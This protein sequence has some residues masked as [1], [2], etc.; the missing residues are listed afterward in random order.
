[1]LKGNYLITGASGSMG[2]TAL[3]RL[4]DV[5]GINVRAADLKEPRVSGDNISF[6][7]ADLK[8]LETC[9]EIVK[10]IDY[11]L[12]FAA[13]LSTAPVMAKNPV[14]HVTSNMIINSQM[15]E[16]AYFAGVKKFLWLSS[17]T[18][19]PQK[20]EPLKEEDMFKGDPP[21]NY[22]SV[23]WMSRY[24]ET[25]C[26]MYAAKLKNPMTTIIL[27]PTNI[28]SEYESFNLEDSHVLPALIRKAVERQDPIEVWGTGEQKK[29][30]VYADDVFDACLLALEKIDSFDTFNIGYG[31]EYSIKE[32]LKTILE[33]DNYNDAKI[34]HNT[35]KPST[36]SKRL[37]DTTKIKKVLGFKPKTTVKEGIAKMIKWY[38]DNQ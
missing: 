28:Y 16:V 24:T 29:D 5:P 9:K 34:I 2:T 1:M 18:G 15:L 10:N 4:K 33:I 8:N 6:V 31:K 22:F 21:D 30:L 36:I 25:L 35:S 19:Y 23:G 7:K 17:T 14:S 11:V 27:R 3:L 32:L 37:I 38:K 26:R 12:M 20:D 13:I